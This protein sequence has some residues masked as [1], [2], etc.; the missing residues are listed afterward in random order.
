MRHIQTMT[1][2][3]LNSILLHCNDDIK[4]YNIHAL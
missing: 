4:C 3:I 2:M 1:D